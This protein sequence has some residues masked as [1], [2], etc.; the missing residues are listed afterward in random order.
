M[1]AEQNSLAATMRCH[2]PG[3]KDPALTHSSADA[4]V[5]LLPSHADQPSRR[6]SNTGFAPLTVVLDF[7]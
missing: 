7:A 3:W 1:G 6:Q 2:P 4:V 5:V